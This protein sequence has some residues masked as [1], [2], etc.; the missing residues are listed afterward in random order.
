MKKIYQIVFIIS[1]LFFIRG[2]ESLVFGQIDTTTIQ[3]ALAGKIVCIQV[4]TLVDDKPLPTVNINGVPHYE[5]KVKDTT[6]T[7]KDTTK[8]TIR[9]RSCGTFNGNNRPLCIIDGILQ[10][11]DF[12]LTTISPEDIE[13]IT[14]L[15]GAVA[16]A[17]YGSR[18]ANGVILITLKKKEIK[19]EKTEKTVEEIAINIFPN[20]TSD[21]V[22]IA[23]NLKEKSAVE[24]KIY[25]LQTLESYEVVKEEYEAG[26]QKINYKTDF[27]KNGIYNLKIKIGNQII[28]R[29]LVIEN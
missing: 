20:P 25:N 24:I 18:G 14:V 8:T 5:A 9:I 23:L 3:T 12:V 11:S 7:V 21:F 13:S 16:T 10:E 28:E 26:S 4:I 15:K 29:K 27:L 19:E 17:L 2:Q 22:N 1:V 6:Q